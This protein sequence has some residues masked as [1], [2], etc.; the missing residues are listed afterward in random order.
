[1]TKFCERCG[2]ETERYA[3]GQCKPC[4]SEYGRYD[5]P[6]EKIVETDNYLTDEAYITQE[7]RRALARENTVRLKA[8]KANPPPQK[9]RP[10]PIETK[11]VA[12]VSLLDLTNTAAPENAAGDENAIFRDSFRLTVGARNRDDR[13][14]M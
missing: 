3:N 8:F 5:K 4:K 11:N 7:R 12:R 9:D 2:K 14:P 10:K 1:M 13:R 6:L